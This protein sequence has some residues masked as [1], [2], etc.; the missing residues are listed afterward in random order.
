MI[1]VIYG[2]G[3]VMSITTLTLN[4]RYHKPDKNQRVPIDGFGV[5]VHEAT[6]VAEICL[7]IIAGI[8]QLIAVV[9]MNKVLIKQG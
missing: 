4:L 7:L 2:I 6:S 8:W 3:L 1:G 9:R 5:T